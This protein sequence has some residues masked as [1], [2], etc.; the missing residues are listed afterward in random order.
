[1]GK[2]EIDRDPAALFLFETVGVDAGKGLHQR[3]LAVIDVPRC[4]G[5]DVL[6]AMVKDAA[7]YFGGFPEYFS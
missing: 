4:S 2:S 3:G 7:R 6:H 1:M 5:D